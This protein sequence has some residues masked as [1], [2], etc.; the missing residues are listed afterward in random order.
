MFGALNNRDWASI[1]L[2]TVALVV[3]LRSPA[4]RSAMAGVVRAALVP[5]IVGIVMLLVAY[6][7]LMVGWAFEVGLWR[8]VLMKETV[9]WFVGSAIA[10]TFSI[11]TAPLRD[12]SFFRNAV[13]NA[14]A[15]T[16]FVEFYVN[17]FVFP[18]LVELLLLPTIVFLVMLSTFASSDDKYRPAKRLADGLLITIGIALTSFVTLRLV[19]DW[20]EVVT[21]HSGLSFILP[22]G[23]TIAVLPLVYAVGLGSSYEIARQRIDFA[24]KDEAARRRAKRALFRVLHVRREAVA[25][26]VGRWPSRLAHSGSSR[27][28]RTVVRAYLAAH[29]FGAA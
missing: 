12:R 24:T 21:V 16:V 1:I 26:F 8:P 28:A 5:R 11:V 2:L 25:G 27:E 14:V 7:G 29:N 20:D 15:V 13:M 3:A 18:L 22:I 10:L 17:L 23:L 4:L 9:V 6:T 19:R